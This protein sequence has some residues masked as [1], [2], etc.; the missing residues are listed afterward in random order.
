MTSLFCYDNYVDSAILSPSTSDILYPVSN[1]QVESTVKEWRSTSTSATLDVDL[2]N[3]KEV[4]HIFMAPHALEGFK[5]DNLRIYANSIPASWGAPPYDSGLITS[6]PNDLVYLG[7]NPSQT[8]RYWRFEISYPTN[9]G[10]SKIFLGK[11]IELPFNNIDTVWTFNQDISAEIATGVYGQRFI[12]PYNKIKSFS[13][14]YRLLTKDELDVVEALFE[15]RGVNK[16][17]WFMLDPDEGLI[18][19]KEKLAGY[20]WIANRPTITHNNYG[21]YNINFDILQVI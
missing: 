6:Y 1:I 2:N 13:L 12:T 5:F 9:T 18:N 11:S 10:I 17:I 8:Y 19:S 7:L 21:L 14:S 4:A 3:P 16:P 15:D 20:F